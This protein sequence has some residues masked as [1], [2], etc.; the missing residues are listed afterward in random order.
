VVGWLGVRVVRQWVAGCQVKCWRVKVGQAT[1]SPPSIFIFFTY[2]VDSCT[3]DKRNYRI[4]LNVFK[5]LQ[6]DTLFRCF[7]LKKMFYIYLLITKFIK[8]F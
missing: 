3:A 4:L 8:Y 1:L 7:V 6:K 5:E 2:I